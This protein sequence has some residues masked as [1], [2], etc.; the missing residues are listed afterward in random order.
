MTKH[1]NLKE[2]RP[3][4]PRIMADLDARMDRFIITKRGK[5]VAIMMAV[6]D[7][8]SIM[9]TIDILSNKGL[10]KKIR[11]AEAD[12]RKGNVKT[13]ALVEKELGIV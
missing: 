2:L 6:D 8:E 1:I 11:Q 13:L 3:R 10:V 7:Y 9:E 12:V 4:L 5:P